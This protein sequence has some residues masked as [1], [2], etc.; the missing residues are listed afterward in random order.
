MID[1]EIGKTVK[2]RNGK[3]A[4]VI[5]QSKFGKWLLA[6]T[7]ENAEE[8]PVTHWHNNDGSFYADIESE[9]DVTGV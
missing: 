2:L 1:L 8:P 4:Q 7:G 9:L 3:Y 5:F 6:E